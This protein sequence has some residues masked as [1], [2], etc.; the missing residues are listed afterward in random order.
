M[1]SI[2]IITPN[3]LL[4]ASTA[5]VTLSSSQLAIDLVPF[6]LPTKLGASHELALGKLSFLTSL[7]RGKYPAIDEIPTSDMKNT[8]FI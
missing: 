5:I 2:I 7:K 4:T 6:P 8:S 1:R 3:I